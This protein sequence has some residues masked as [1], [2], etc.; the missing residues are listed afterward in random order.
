MGEDADGQLTRERRRARI[1]D[2]AAEA[3]VSVTTVSHALSGA[4]TVNPR[5]A[6]AS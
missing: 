6:S 3:G 5:L 4:R 2:V 1:S